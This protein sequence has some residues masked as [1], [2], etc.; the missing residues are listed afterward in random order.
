MTFTTIDYTDHSF[1]NCDAI[2]QVKD[3]LE[4][5]YGGLD[6]VRTPATNTE[7]VSILQGCLPLL[8]EQVTAETLIQQ[9]GQKKYAQL[10]N[11]CRQSNILNLWYS[12]ELKLILDAT[13]AAQMRVMVLKGADIATSLYPRPELR[14][15]HDI[16]LMVQPKDL[17]ATI[18][19]LEKLGYHYHQEYRFEAVSERRA[20]FVYV[21]QTPVGYLMFEI[22]TSPH[23][24]EWGVSFDAVQLWERARS[25]T[26]AG[27]SAY[28]M[29]LEDLLLYLCWHYRSHVFGR[30]IWLYDIAL[31][32][33]HHADQLDWTL[34]RRLAR[35][36]G[37]MATIYYTVRWCQQTFHITI[38]HDAQ[39][40]QCMPPVFIQRL[41]TR[42]V[43]DDL[44]SVLCRTAQRE[45]KLLHYLMV[46]NINTLC[47]VGWRTV[48]PG[49]AHIGYRYMEHS[50]L[51]LHLFWLYYPLHPLLALRT[52][53]RARSNKKSSHR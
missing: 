13:A 32:L 21:K 6:Q 15:F 42:L 48:F 11:L 47:L 25:I 10:R 35:E 43:G 14:P 37:L 16:D 51:P 39:I 20:A 12:A 46:D 28:G 34:V 23:E 41:I 50:R 38:P 40:E 27:M 31:L 29:G 7:S 53:F 19:I 36:Q 33:Q 52:Y 24:N 22:H 3:A 1:R 49:P 45:R 30:L 9:V 18:A 4:Y 2:L 17:G 5:V 8:M 26:I 44:T